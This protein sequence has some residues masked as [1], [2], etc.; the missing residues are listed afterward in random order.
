MNNPTEGLEVFKTMIALG[1]VLGF[2]GFYV[3]LMEEMINKDSRVWQVFAGTT[4]V[5][6]ITLAWWAIGEIDKAVEVG[7]KTVE[8]PVLPPFIVTVV[9]L[10][11]IIV[12]PA[13]LSVGG[14]LGALISAAGI[15]LIVVS[16][17]VGYSSAPLE[18]QGGRTE[19]AQKSVDPY[20]RLE[21]L[22]GE[23]ARAREGGTEQTGSRGGALERDQRR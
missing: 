19:V 17:N 20:I 16:F 9:G 3:S 11:L 2:A 22:G 21:E 1:G 13:I 6:V 18:G 8:S 14:G 7:L 5:P 12:V 15:G 4:V 10:L 23:E